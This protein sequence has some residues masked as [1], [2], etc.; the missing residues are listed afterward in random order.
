MILYPLFGIY[1]DVVSCNTRRMLLFKSILK[2]KSV[3]E[4][5]TILYL[6]FCI[7][8]T[9]KQTKVYWQQ[10]NTPD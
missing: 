5:C 4:T 1:I 2:I 9:S 3:L 10:Q 6:L 7:L 8:Y